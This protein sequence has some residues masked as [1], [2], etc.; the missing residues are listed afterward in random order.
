MGGAMPLSVG[1]RVRVRE[2]AEKYGGLIG[3][4]IRREWVTEH[5]GHRREHPEAR[6]VDGRL[7]VIVQL[8]DPPAGFEPVILC[9]EEQV[10]LA[11]S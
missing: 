2:D 9:Y 11:S 5:K 10:A 4:I 6:Q 3:V 7:A 8:E 1:Q